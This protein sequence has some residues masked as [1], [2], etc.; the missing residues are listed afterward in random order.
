[1]DSKNVQ[2][3]WDYHHEGK[4]NFE[5]LLTGSAGPEVWRNLGVSKLIKPNTVVL[6]IG[7]GLGYCTIELAR[8][9]C[10]VHAL[11]I[12]PVALAKVSRFTVKTWLPS[13]LP[14]I[15]TDNF[16]L[17]ISNLVAQHMRDDELIFQIRNVLKCLKP[18]GLF[19]MQFAFSL[20][21]EKN[22]NPDP[23][24]EL[25]K[26]GGVGRSL[27]GVARIV[28]QTGGSIV[29]ASRIAI[30]PEQGAGWYAVHIVRPDYPLPNTIGQQH[31]TILDRIAGNARRAVRSLV[32]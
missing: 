13:Q 9:R 29:W 10:V 8:R 15:P 21:T 32:D 23:S 2:A 17:A 27:E 14:E 12:S 20:D 28:N 11:D 25:I 16:D 26:Y 5:L 31:L 30:F 24:L 3:W 7:V 1:V 22:D 19:A 4:G 18:T 6:N